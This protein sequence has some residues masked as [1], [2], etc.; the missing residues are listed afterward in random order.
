MIGREMCKKVDQFETFREIFLKWGGGGW[1]IVANGVREN[2]RKCLQFLLPAVQ[3]QDTL[4]A[5]THVG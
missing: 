2:I 1:G 5:I 4:T 3:A